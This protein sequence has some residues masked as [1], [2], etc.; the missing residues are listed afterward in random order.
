MKHEETHEVMPI[1]RMVNGKSV[2]MDK[3]PADMLDRVEMVGLV[4]DRL[5]AAICSG[6]WEG[7]LKLEQMFLAMA[8]MVRKEI[9]QQ[10]GDE[11]SHKTHGP[12]HARRSATARGVQKTARSTHART[13]AATIR[14]AQPRPRKGS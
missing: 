12:T 7:V 4:N 2:R 3:L 10:H 14:P 8:A 13:A 9:D 11:P 5:E 6:K 1:T